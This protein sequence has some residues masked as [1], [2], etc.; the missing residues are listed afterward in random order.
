MHFARVI[1]LQAACPEFT[2]ATPPW[3]WSLPSSRCYQVHL[4]ANFSNSIV[5]T[6]TYKTSC[7]QANLDVKF[8]WTNNR[9]ESTVDDGRKLDH[10]TCINLIHQRLDGKPKSTWLASSGWIP[11]SIDR[12]FTFRCRRSDKCKN[13]QTLSF[14]M[15]FWYSLACIDDSVVEQVTSQGNFQ[16]KADNVISLC[17]NYGWS[18]TADIK[19]VHIPST[20]KNYMHHVQ[21]EGCNINSP[22][23]DEKYLI[24]VRQRSG[25]AI[26]SRVQVNIK[27][28]FT[29]L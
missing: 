2:S 5:K 25:A 29:R 23:W 4:K 14:E 7:W 15:T 26:I 12:L 20:G 9:I 6:K 8:A 1:I 17:H 10:L 27:S 22:N 16:G 13:H 18:T 11:F 21:S 3:L 28:G 24:M 19:S